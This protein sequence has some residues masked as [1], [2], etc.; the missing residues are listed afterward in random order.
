MKHSYLFVPGNELKKLNKALETNAHVIVIDL[1][2]SVGR[3]FKS[4]ARE[5]IH[6]WLL[7]QKNITKTLYLRMNPLHSEF[8]E[9]DL[10][11]LL[12]HKEF[13]GVIVSKVESAADLPDVKLLKKLN[14][15]LLPLLET[16]AGVQNVTPI[17]TA[18]ESIEQVVFGVMDYCVDLEISYRPDHPLIDYAKFQLIVTARALGKKPP[19]DTIYPY[20]DDLDG[21]AKDAQKALDLGMTAKLCIHPQQVDIVNRIFRN[22]YADVTWAAKVKIAYET[23]DDEGLHVVN[24]DGEMIDYPV[25][26]RALQILKRGKYE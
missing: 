8:A 15:K 4:E 12:K 11:L 6:E 22:L 17:M 25:Y 14:I 20:I 2:D 16:A 9:A 23:A 21:L 7:Q 13:S 5:L 1:E 18:D 19:I 10:K 24:V 3:E 26:L